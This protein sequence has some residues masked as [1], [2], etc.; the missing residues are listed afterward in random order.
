[1]FLQCISV[2]SKSSLYEQ[3]TVNYIHAWY[4]KLCMLQVMQ[5]ACWHCISAAIMHSSSYYLLAVCDL[6]WWRYW[7][8]SHT[9]PNCGELLCTICVCTW[10]VGVW[11][12]TFECLPSPPRCDSTHTQL[13]LCRQWQAK[14]N[15][16]CRLVNFSCFMHLVSF[17]NQVSYCLYE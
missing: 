8:T 3:L 4:C 2:L 10:R 17:M 7:H 13:A 9:S 14:L 1:M 12:S 15:K 6:H 5:Q 11:V 16:Y